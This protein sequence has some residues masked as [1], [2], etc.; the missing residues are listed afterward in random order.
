MI[1]DILALH[2]VAPYVLHSPRHSCDAGHFGTCFINNNILE[3]DNVRV[4][5]SL[6][7][8][9]FPN[10][11]RGEVYSAITLSKEV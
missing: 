1:N 11:G 6:E 10:G 2:F 3:L 9:D 8:L 4:S 5:H 7:E